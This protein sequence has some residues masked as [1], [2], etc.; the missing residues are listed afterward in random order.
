MK[1]RKAF[2]L[3]EILITVALT[4]LIAALA[5]GPIVYVVGQITELEATYSD[6]AALRRAAMFMAQ[7]VSSSLRLAPASVRVISHQ[8]LGGG[9]ND[10]LIVASSAHTRQNLPAGSVIY[11]L[12]RRSLFNDRH[13]PGLYRWILPGVLPGDAMYDR[14]DAEDGQLIVPHVTDMNLSVFV[15]PDWVPHYYGNLPA[16]MRFILARERDG[17]ER[18]SIEYVFVFPR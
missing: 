2:T 15:P 16:G 5:F 9:H 12:V 3:L 1:P 4:G 8:E 18:E 10:T 7:D 14:L 11:R 13:V 6:E 17:E